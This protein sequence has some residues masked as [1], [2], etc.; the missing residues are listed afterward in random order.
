MVERQGRHYQLGEP[1]KENI[2]MAVKYL[3][4]LDIRGRSVRVILKM[5][6]IILRILSGGLGLKNITKNI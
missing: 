4:L 2:L 5:I 3:K 6:T 1:Q